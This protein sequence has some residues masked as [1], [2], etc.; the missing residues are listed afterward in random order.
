MSTPSLRALHDGPGLLVLPNAWDAASA[1]VFEAAGFPAIA[2]TSSGVAQSLGFADGENAP[3]DGMLAAVRRIVAAVAVPVTADMEGGYGLPP[4]EFA[5]RVADT[6]AAGLNFED[7]DHRAGGTAPLWDADKQAARIA[8]IKAAAPDLFLNARVDVHVRQAGPLEEA[9]RR[10]RLYRDAGADGVYP[11]AVDDE[12]T[13]S[14]F[15]AAVDAPVNVLSRPG[16]P[17]LARLA[18][19]GVR[20]VTFG[21]GLMRAAMVRTKERADE[22]RAELDGM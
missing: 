21:G 8:A 13:I 9:L 14:A 3:V 4:A 1:R 6:G 17:P 11:I 12:E 2:T 20:R 5:A 19:L 18:E 22:I 10:A 7:T 16:A 15:V